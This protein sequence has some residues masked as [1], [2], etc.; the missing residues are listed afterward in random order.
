MTN[1]PFVHIGRC[2]HFETEILVLEVQ[3][4]LEGE[5]EHAEAAL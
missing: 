5:E 2:K 1:V 4:Y 3:K